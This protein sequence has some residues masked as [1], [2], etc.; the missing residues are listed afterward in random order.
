[1]TRL[2]LLLSTMMLLAQ[3]CTQQ[4]PSLSAVV[5]RYDRGLF[6]TAQTMGTTLARQSHGEA[7][8]QAAYVTGMAALRQSGRNDAARTW[9]VEACTSNDPGL[10]ARSEA[11]L[12][13]LDRREGNE[14]GAIRHYERA[15]PGL[16]LAQRRDAAQAAI[17]ALRA[18]GDVDG[19]DAWTHR[20]AGSDP[21]PDTAHWTLQAG[22]FK[23]RSAADDL[24]LSLLTRSSNSGLSTP[25]I[26]R[27]TRGGRAL[28]LVQFGG[29][30]TRSQAE[31]A[32]RQLR[33]PDLLIV[34]VE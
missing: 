4:K 5:E 23:S 16:N 27:S 28:W 25:R 2:L 30:Q 7:R 33:D 29:F 24:R 22:A 9:L 18:A 8:A 12:G 31:S 1:M 26:H 21:A 10:R 17:L 19:V 13:E 6:A 11:M 3:A 20:L 15:W 34:R 14:Q 32:R